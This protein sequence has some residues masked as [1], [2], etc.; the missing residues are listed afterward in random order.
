[1]V[2]TGGNTLRWSRPHTR[3]GHLR[4]CRGPEFGPMADLRPRSWETFSGGVFGYGPCRFDSL[5]EMWLKDAARGAAV[6]LRSVLSNPGRPSPSR[7]LQDHK[8]GTG[9][10]PPDF[11]PAG[12]MV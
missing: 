12:A 6:A 7:R 3:D 9:T 8:R 5:S 4:S 2:T 11:R 10:G 1:M